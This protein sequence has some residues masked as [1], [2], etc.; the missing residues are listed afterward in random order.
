[1]YFF[2][3][4]ELNHLKHRNKYMRLQYI[5]NAGSLK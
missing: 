5:T 1:M 3:A 4:K 2:L